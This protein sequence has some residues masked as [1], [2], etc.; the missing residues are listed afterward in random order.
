MSYFFPNSCSNKCGHPRM[1]PSLDR[2]VFAFFRVQATNFVQ[3]NI[4]ANYLQV[5]HVLDDGRNV[6]ERFIYADT[7]Q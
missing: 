3:I 1:H 6:Q 7:G 5:M 2:N 4:K